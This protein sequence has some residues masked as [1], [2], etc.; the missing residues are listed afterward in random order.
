MK[1]RLFYV[2]VILAHVLG[3]VTS[4]ATA[5]PAAAGALDGLQPGQSVTYTQK[6][7]I[8]IVFVGYDQ[9]SID[10]QDFLGQL[11]ASYEPIVRYPAFYGLTGRDMGL[12]FNFDYRVSFSGASF[13]NRFFNFLKA[14]GTPGEPTVFQAAYN[15]QEKNVLDVTAPV[16]YIE[17][18]PAY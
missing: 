5:A 18:L 10:L 3:L 8:K 15:D 13:A 6:I 1:R 17:N 14:T 2:I 4:T 16:L 9:N 11:P 7:P 12:H